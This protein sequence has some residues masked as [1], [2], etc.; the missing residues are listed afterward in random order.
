MKVCVIGKYSKII[1]CKIADIKSDAP[2]KVADTIIESVVPDALSVAHALGILVLQRNE[3]FK[4]IYI[5]VVFSRQF[6]V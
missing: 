2:M 3:I 6:R 5:G 4:S 1:Y